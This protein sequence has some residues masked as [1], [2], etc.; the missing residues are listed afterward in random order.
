MIMTRTSPICI[1][2]IASFIISYIPLLA[3]FEDQAQTLNK[4]NVKS[5]IRVP[6]QEN[7]FW[8]YWRS[9]VLS[10]VGGVAAASASIWVARRTR[11]GTLDQAVHEERLKR[12]P[13]LIKTG[14]PFAV[15][16]PQNRGGSGPVDRSSLLNIGHSMSQWYFDGGGLLMSTESRDL[17]FLLALAITRAASVKG[18]GLRVPT[19]SD[20]RTVVDSYSITELKKGLQIPRDMEGRY[21]KN[22]DIADA[23]RTIREWK[24]GQGPSVNDADRF[25]DF[26]FLQS[27]SSALR[28]SLAEDLRSRR[29]PS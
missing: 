11:R 6:R 17:Y 7:D 18:D 15:Y 23:V 10:L 3:A 13:E 22:I 21:W 2:V 5:E 4:P 1:V 14:A 20:Y 28:T 19:Y 12:Y 16:F 25:R 24:F 26:V 8:A 29:R 9:I 27:L